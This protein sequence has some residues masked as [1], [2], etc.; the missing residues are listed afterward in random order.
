VEFETG[1]E[2]LSGRNDTVGSKAIR[3]VC[4]QGTICRKSPG[5]DRVGGRALNPPDDW[6]G[7]G[8]QK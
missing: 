1:E 5:E 4:R 2:D 7:G 8:K 6:G 3:T